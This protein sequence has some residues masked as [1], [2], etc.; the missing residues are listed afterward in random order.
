MMTS[1]ILIMQFIC[2]VCE[3][4]NETDDAFEL[5]E[6]VECIDCGTEFEITNLS[7]FIIQEIECEGEDWGQ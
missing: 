2:P 5:N 1:N 3:G 4:Q 7:P 6:L